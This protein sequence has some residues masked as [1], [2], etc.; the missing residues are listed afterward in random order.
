MSQPLISVVSP[1]Y[2]C[3]GCLVELHRRITAAL[4][5]ITGDFELILVNDGSPDGA[6]Q[7][8]EALCRAD[9]RV[10]GVNLSRNFG[11]H[12]A[13]AAGLERSRGTWVVVMDCD[14]Q[15]RPEEIPAL[16]NATSSGVDIVFAV[17]SARND[18]VLRRWGSRAFY[19][20]LSYMTDTA[21]DARIANF[22]VYHRKVID[23]V[24]ALPEQH[25]YFPTMIR[26][27][28]F[29]ASE[30]PVEHASRTIGA[31]S[32]NMG[33]ML[34][35]AGATI[36]AFSDKPLR[37]VIKVGMSI[38][39]AAFLFA[40]LILYRALIGDVAVLGWASLII[41]IWF[42]AGFVI[43]V[44]GIVGLYVGRAFDE[45]KQRPIYIVRQTIND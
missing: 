44:L 3:A 23:A 1:V 12:P 24:C 41:S 19:R 14:L 22:G 21:Q 7:V 10:R 9:K 18:P 39:L 25:R 32:Y 8:I 5:P 6:W 29:N 43:A 28:G 30:I 31:S 35:L 13:I 40:L 27:V 20:L 34:R 4:E 15:D 42:F 45:G 33:K 17:R 11:Q 37:L 2:G 26:W 38:A 36:L 16:L